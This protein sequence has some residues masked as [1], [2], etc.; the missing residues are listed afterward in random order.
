[1]GVVRKPFE[2]PHD[3]AET[4][5]FIAVSGAVKFAALMGKP[6]IIRGP[7]GIGKSTSLVL[8][9]WKDPDVALINAER[10]LKKTKD[11]MHLIAEALD[12]HVVS[13]SNYEFRK[14][15]AIYVRERAESGRYLI[16]DNAHWIDLEIIQEIFDLWEYQG[17][18]II[19]CG[20]EELLR[21]PSKGGSLFEHVRTRVSRQVDLLRSDPDDFRLFAEKRN[22]QGDEAVRAIVNYGMKTSMREV[23]HLLDAAREGSDSEGPLSLGHIQFAAE[24]IFQDRSRAR[25]ALSSK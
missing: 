14:W 6:T 10:D 11:Y 9:N 8:L 5:T 12:I 25:R 17:L 16:I 24:Y 19:L 23:S 15:M 1:M 7:V 2:P 3:I 13:Q 21:R 18:P 22:V 4:N 20:N